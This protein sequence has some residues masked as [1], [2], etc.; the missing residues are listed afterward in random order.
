MIMSFECGRL[1]NQLFQ[2]AALKEIFPKHRLILIGNADLKKTLTSLDAKIM[3]T[4]S[5][6]R[7]IVHGTRKV[8]FFLAFVRLL[9]S[10]REVRVSSAYDVEIKR[11]LVPGLYFLMPSFFQHNAIVNR[12]KPKFVVRSSL[13]DRALNWL[14]SRSLL[15]EKTNLVFVHVRRGDYLSWPSQDYP[16]VLN[17]DWYIGAMEQIRSQVEDP[18]FLFFTDDVNYAE[19]CFGNQPNI[20][21]SK[22]DQFV[23]LAL[24][25]FCS[26]G[27]LSASSFAWWGAWFSQ[28]NRKGREVGVY[29]APKYWVG[30]RSREWYPEGFQTNWIT[31]IE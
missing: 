5:L 1:G 9:G 7:W 3:V 12:L 17:K 13:R 25:S 31:Y 20:F 19:D 11:G 16:A 14:K 23:D 29:L 18:I 24:M 27:I 30:H 15:V 2:Y 10:I 21:I 6:P 4:D 8:L 28:K 22:N 26:H